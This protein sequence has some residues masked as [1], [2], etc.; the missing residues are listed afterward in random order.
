MKE[1]R[2]KADLLRELKLVTAE[3][4]EIRIML[5]ESCTDL[6]KARGTVE[7]LTERCLWSARNLV[8]ERNDL[9][10]RIDRINLRLVGLGF[11]NAAGFDKGTDA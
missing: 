4:N 10:A 7:E 2:T 11:R 3:R 1:N 5:K 6:D 9:Q 8:Q